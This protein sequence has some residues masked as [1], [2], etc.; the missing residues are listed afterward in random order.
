MIILLYQARR[1]DKEDEDGGKAGRKKIDG[2]PTHITSLFILHVG[3]FFLIVDCGQPK[4]FQVSFNA[5]R[6]T[7]G[8]GGECFTAGCSTRTP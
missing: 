7:G 3:S 4:S 1:A 5:S 8:R 6:I 2:A